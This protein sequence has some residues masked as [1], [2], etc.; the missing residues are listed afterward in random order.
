MTKWTKRRNGDIVTT[1]RVEYHVPLAMIEW[2]VN[3]TG[4]SHEKAM[5]FIRQDI[6]RL[7]EGWH[8]FYFDPTNDT[9]TVDHVD[10][11]HLHEKGGDMAYGGPPIVRGTSR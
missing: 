10:D 11:W 7:A 5:R 8:T 2:L 4:W 1:I 3:Y 9:V 6:N